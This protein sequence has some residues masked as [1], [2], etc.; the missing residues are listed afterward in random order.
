MNRGLLAALMVVA[1]ILLMTL[2]GNGALAANAP[3]QAVRND[4]AREIAAPQTQVTLA[5]TQVAWVAAAASSTSF[6]G[7]SDVWAGYGLGTAT[8][9][10]A[11]RGLVLFDLS[12][13]PAN[14]LISDARLNATITAGQGAS[15]AFNYDVGE[16]LAPWT[17]AVTW[18]TKPSVQFHGIPSAAIAAT[19]G[20][21]S[22]DV[23]RIVEF[24][25]RDGD[26]NYGFGLS[27]WYDTDPN[28][29]EQARRFSDLRLVITY[30]VPTA[31]LT[32]THAPTPT[33]TPTL[34][35]QPI[36][37]VTKSDLF[38]PV[39]AGENIVYTLRVR[40]L[41]AGAV[42]PLR[43]VDTLPPGTSFVEASDGGVFDERG[44]VTWA[45]H[46]LPAGGSTRV[47]LIFARRRSP[48]AC[49]PTGPV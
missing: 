29:V 37:E 20:P 16:V 38:D 34:S 40:N 28:P 9:R 49:S 46:T 1:A 17:Q 48:V 45:L 6:G 13:I 5:P 42:T 24:W 4:L 12:G 25:R 39:V 3:A 35:G 30:T 22:W 47:R 27:R 8:V 18:S 21:V 7:H 33:P 23:T 2:V 36:L 15:S 26:P 10:G 11:L 41:S 19:S 14:A 32:P 44:S 43:L 31:T